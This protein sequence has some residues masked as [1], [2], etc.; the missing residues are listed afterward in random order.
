[1]S[2]ADSTLFTGTM[3]LRKGKALFSLTMVAALAACGGGGGDVAGA[4]GSG[5][6]GSYVAGP[7]TGF[8]SVIINGVRYDDSAARIETEDGEGSDDDGKGTLDKGDLRLGMIAEVEGGQVTTGTNGA[9]STGTASVIRYINELKGPVSNVTGTGFTL[10]GQTVSV[11]PATIYENVSGIGAITGGN[12]AYAEVYAF[13]DATTSSYNA[14]RVEC[15]TTQPDTYRLYGPIGNLTDSTFTINGLTVTYTGVS[16]VPTLSNGVVV[17]VRL[18]PV[19]LTSN[20]VSPAATAT[21]VKLNTKAA[22]SS[23]KASVEGL[24]TDYLATAD[25]ATFKVNGVSVVLNASTGFED[26]LQKADLADGVRVEVEGALVDGVLTARS[27]EEESETDLEDQSEGQEFLG[28]VSNVLPESNG[29]TFTLTT[30]GGRVLTVTYLNTDFDEPADQTGFGNN[31]LVE[32]KGAL[33]SNGTSVDATK[34]QL[35]D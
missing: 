4:P 16:E 10:L 18:S 31:A 11:N 32:V 24:I 14:T 27:I 12:C 9:L 20:T 13:Y 19:S 2:L 29:G 35:E 21:R 34:I 22:R 15:K 23:S 33:G 5:G 8:G 6:T 30:S 25:G 28:R 7:I 3:P 17:R 26:G 1:M